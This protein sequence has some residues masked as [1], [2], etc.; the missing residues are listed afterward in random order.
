MVRA[1]TPTLPKDLMYIPGV[2]GFLGF[3]DQRQCLAGDHDI[4]LSI[5][6][7]IGHGKPRFPARRI[8][9]YIR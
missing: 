2:D 9:V 6:A 5:T 4:D 8:R 3:D 1:E 7:S